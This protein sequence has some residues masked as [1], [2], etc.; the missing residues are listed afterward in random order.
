MPAVDGF[1]VRQV[2]VD[3]LVASRNT[4]L[5]H[6]RG[7]LNVPTGS[8][9]VPVL[10]MRVRLPQPGE[11]WLIDRQ[12]GGWSFAAVLYSPDL[13][14]AGRDTGW[15]SM[16]KAWLNLPSGSVCSARRVQRR[17]TVR[18]STPALA[19]TYTG[20]VTPRGWSAGNGGAALPVM[21]KAGTVGVLSVSDN[22]DEHGVWSLTLTAGTGGVVS[23]CTWLCDGNIPSTL[24][25]QQPERA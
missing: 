8:Y 13:Y 22:Q 25:M 18:I 4:A 16:P 9:E 15:V 12:Y 2:V 10:P 1:T 20:N 7:G 19:G 14:L 3:S 11:M 24:G 23:E 21:G 6:T 5:V 17:V